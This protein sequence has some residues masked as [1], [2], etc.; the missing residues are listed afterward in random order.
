MES[1]P[2]RNFPNRTNVVRA[3]FDFVNGTGISSSPTQTGQ[4]PQVSISAS[5]DNG[6]TWDNPRLRKLGVQSNAKQ[7][8]YGM[9]WGMTASAGASIS[10]MRSTPRS[11]EPR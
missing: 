1:A 9:N 7:T 5:R 8:V 2:V 10:P 4:N 6:A 11:W 3:D